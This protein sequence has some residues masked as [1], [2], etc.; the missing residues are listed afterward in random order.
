VTFGELAELFVKEHVK[1]KRKSST[2]ESYS[3]VLRRYALPTLGQ[4]KADAIS[5]AEI[6]RLHINLEDKPYQANRLLAVIKSL[7]SFAERRGLVPDNFNPAKKIEKFPEDRRERFLTS[8]ELERLGAS[9]RK[10]ETVGIPWHRDS[11]K[12]ESKHLAK[13]ENQRTPLSLQAAAALRL[14][15]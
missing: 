10:G 1:A 11:G 5:R 9:I 2:A 4:R 6:A 13:D 8:E 14:L 15:I 7:Y 12:T 3:A